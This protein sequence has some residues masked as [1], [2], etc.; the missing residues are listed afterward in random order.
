MLYEFE[1]C[2]PNQVKY[3]VEFTGQESN[4]DFVYLNDP[5][6]KNWFIISKGLFP[7]N[8]HILADL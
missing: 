4:N 2:K 5:L 8:F 7:F 3:R 6:I 1:E